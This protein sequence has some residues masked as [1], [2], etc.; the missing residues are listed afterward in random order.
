M[1]PARGRRRRGA[2]RRTGRT[3]SQGERGE[4]GGMLGSRLVGEQRRVIVCDGFAAE[5]I[6]RATTQRLYGWAH[7]QE[8]SVRA[9]TRGRVCPSPAEAPNE[10]SRTPPTGSWPTPPVSFSTGRSRERP[11]SAPRSSSTRR[12]PR[13]RARGSR[14][15]RPR[16][17][18]VARRRD[19]RHHVD[20]Q[21][22]RR[23]GRVRDGGVRRALTVDPCAE[24]GVVAG[25]RERR[26]RITT[27]RMPR[28]GIVVGSAGTFYVRA[29]GI[30]QVS[31]STRPRRTERP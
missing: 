7:V 21:G 13:G 20:P 23:Q 14:D 28:C 26:I 18:V 30:E 22:R 4:C 27:P 6:A 25:E 15:P 10:P 9:W 19:P 24:A 5:T 29:R 17:P 8:R 16:R 31:R 1:L 3:G 2:Q 11:S 12:D